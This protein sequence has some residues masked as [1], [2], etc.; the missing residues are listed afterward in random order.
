MHYNIGMRGGN[1]EEA[2]AKKENVDSEITKR[3]IDNASQKRKPDAV[4]GNKEN[5]DSQKR[6]L[7]K[8]LDDKENIDAPQK[9]IFKD[10][11]NVA[12]LQ[13][14]NIDVIGNVNFG[15]MIGLILDIL[16]DLE[17]TEKDDRKKILKLAFDENVYMS[18]LLE[19]TK[20]EHFK[21]VN[22]FNLR[23]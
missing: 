17:E 7:D 23:V 12:P 20:K 11:E 6:K 13:Q 10:K 1:Y 18:K 5:I 21:F 22:L 3:W 8:V 15:K 2:L 16:E 19:T 4:F 9:R 14:E